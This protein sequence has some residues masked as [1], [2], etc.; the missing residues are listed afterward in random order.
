MKGLSGG[1]LAPWGEVPGCSVPLVYEADV[2]G[3]PYWYEGSGFLVRFK[4]GLYV[5]SAGHCVR[6][7]DLEALRVPASVNMPI[8]LPLSQ[9]FNAAELHPSEDCHDVVIMT[10]SP[11]YE[12]PP[13]KEYIPPFPSLGTTHDLRVGEP[14]TVRGFPSAAPRTNIDYDLQHMRWQAGTFGAD[15]LGPSY[16]QHVHKLRFIPSVPLTNFNYMSGSPVFRNPTASSSYQ[17]AGMLI[18][19]GGLEKLGHFVETAVVIKALEEASLRKALSSGLNR[20][21]TAL[22]RGAPD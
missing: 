1:V 8:H 4:E 22:S 18:R 9:I 13:E 16:E 15:Y 19:A 10:V 6:G 11:H 17:L 21:D 5:V 20:M 12:Q 7:K 14:L 2:Q 3:S